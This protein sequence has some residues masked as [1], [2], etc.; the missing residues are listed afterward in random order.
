MPEALGAV[1]EAGVRPPSLSPGWTQAGHARHL[2]DA[3]FAHKGLGSILRE[4]ATMLRVMP[5]ATAQALTEDASQKWPRDVPFTTSAEVARIL[6]GV[7]PKVEP[8]ITPEEFRASVVKAQ[9]LGRPVPSVPRH[10][11]GRV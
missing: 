3:A 7:A 5:T 4:V 6:G 9:R 2:T 1:V 8:L 10:L 11:L